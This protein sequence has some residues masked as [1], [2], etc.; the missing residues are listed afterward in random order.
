MDEHLL[1]WDS[2]GSW[3]QHEGAPRRCPP[4]DRFRGWRAGSR[5]GAAWVSRH[6]CASVKGG[7]A[8]RRELTGAD[9]HAAVQAVWSGR[10]RG[11]HTGSAP[12]RWRSLG[13]ERG[14]GGG[15]QSRP[16]RD[17][18]SVSGGASAGPGS[19]EGR[20]GSRP[21]R[22]GRAGPAQT[23]RGPCWPPIRRRP[24]RP[25]SPATR[26]VMLRA[27]KPPRRGPPHP[28]VEHASAIPWPAGERAEVSAARGRGPG[29]G[30]GQFPRL[31][32]PSAEPDCPRRRP[33]PPVEVSPLDRADGR[34]VRPPAR[35]GSAGSGP[36]LLCVE[37]GAALPHSS[38]AR[39]ARPQ[40]PSG[41]RVPPQRSRTCL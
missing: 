4:R 9:R 1:T 39:S 18:S 32:P 8:G 37:A 33:C 7:C 25:R 6:R 28:P 22:S 17:R 40:R 11:T 24:R 19:E 36:R 16:A 41:V 38:G 35:R 3:C 15:A 2:R 13:P 20:P 30:G 27:R 29:G 21:R 12:L 10:A 34:C 26:A 5:P 23:G 14:W 31:E